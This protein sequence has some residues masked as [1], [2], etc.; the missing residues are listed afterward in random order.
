MSQRVED[1]PMFLLS[2]PRP[3]VARAGKNEGYERETAEIEFDFRAH[4]IERG[5]VAIDHTAS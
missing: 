1:G 4:R 5:M 3:L 2:V